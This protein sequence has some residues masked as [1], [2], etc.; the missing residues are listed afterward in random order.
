MPFMAVFSAM[1]LLAGSGTAY[2][3]ATDEAAV[4]A[5]GDGTISP[6]LGVTPAF[7]SVVFRGTLVVAGA[8]HNIINTTTLSCTFNGN[9]TIAEDPILGQGQGTLSCSGSAAVL[10]TFAP[11]GVATGVAVSASCSLNYQRVGPAVVVTG[12]C[13]ATFSGKGTVTFTRAVAACLFE[14]TTVS[15]TT[16]YLLQCAGGLSGAA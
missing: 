9:S 10:V 15:P 4:V 8:D 12:S 11:P 3:A 6:G 1:T 14:P 2:A 7:Q 16:S 13:T 5:N